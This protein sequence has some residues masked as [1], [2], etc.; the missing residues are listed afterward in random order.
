MKSNYLL[1]VSVITTAIIAVLVCS[2]LLWSKSSLIISNITKS[3]LLSFVSLSFGTYSDEKNAIQ[4]KFNSFLKL[5][6][7]F[8]SYQ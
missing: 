6:H 4:L 3:Q 5:F 2:A 7:I 8:I 1:I